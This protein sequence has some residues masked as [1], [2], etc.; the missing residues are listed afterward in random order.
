MKPKKWP[1]A[2][3]ARRRFTKPTLIQRAV[4]PIV[5]TEPSIFLALIFR[6]I[7]MEIMNG[8]F[9]L[10]ILLKFSIN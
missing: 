8:Q 9:F 10:P 7:L 4:I 2:E 3:V 1:I 6:F 5:A